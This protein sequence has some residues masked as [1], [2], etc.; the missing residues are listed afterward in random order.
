MTYRVSLI[1]AA[2]MLFAGVVQAHSHLESSTPA[3]GSTVSVSPASVVLNFSHEV[4]VA[5]TMN[6]STM[7]H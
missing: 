5:Q 4:R 1:A 7:R 2:L 3:E 6:H